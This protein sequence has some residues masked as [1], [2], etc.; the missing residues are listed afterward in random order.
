MEKSHAMTNGLPTM[1]GVGRPQPDTLKNLFKGRT[2]ANSPLSEAHIL[3]IIDYMI[4]CSDGF[5]TSAFKLINQL[6]ACVA[7]TRWWTADLWCARYVVLGVMI[8]LCLRWQ[9]VVVPADA[10]LWPVHEWLHVAHERWAGCCNAD[11]G[12]GLCESGN[13]RGW[14]QRSRAPFR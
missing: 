3:G 13:S 6:S 8:L 14:H 1:T 12:G 5:L 2:D 9:D 4:T 10:G 7:C 11:G